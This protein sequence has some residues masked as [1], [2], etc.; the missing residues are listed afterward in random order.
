MRET[1]TRQSFLQE[2]K[3]GIFPRAVRSAP[4]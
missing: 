2:A 4:Q 1:A 3:M